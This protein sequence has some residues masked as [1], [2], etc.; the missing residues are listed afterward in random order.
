MITLFE[1]FTDNIWY[2]GSHDDNITSFNT[3]RDTKLNR[4]GT[5][6]SDIEKESKRYGSNIYVVKLHLSKTL[7]LTK[8]GEQGIDNLEG[9]LRELPI[10]DD[11]INRRIREQR[12]WERDYFSPYIILESLDKQYHI[13][14]KLKRKGYDSLCFKEGVGT[15]M[16]VF[17]SSLI[18]I[19]SQHKR[20]KNYDW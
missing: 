11:E 20:E 3:R 15:T 10:P 9:F 19:I 16:V 14:P 2:H 4:L 6:F 13:I 12:F 1:D 8:Y 18:E 17:W 5:Y 7:N